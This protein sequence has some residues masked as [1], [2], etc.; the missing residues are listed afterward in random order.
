MAPPAT[1]APADEPETIVFR[2]RLARLVGLGVGTFVLVAMLIAAVVLFEAFTLADSVGFA[3]LG[4]A[5]W[6]FC[7]REATVRVTARPDR[8]VVRNL[9][10]TRELEWAEVVAVS[11]PQGD[12]WAH[13]DLSDGDTI[14]TMALQRADGEQGIAGAR[15]LA[16]LVHER[17]EAAGPA[18]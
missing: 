18:A 13:L 11:F 17:G 8:L 14:A 16:G 12:P 5:I 7:Y 6:Y 4:I 15:R 10:T 2:P 3:A 9:F 1:P